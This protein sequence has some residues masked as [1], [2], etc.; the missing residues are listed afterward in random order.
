VK[1]RRKTIVIEEQLDVQ[2]RLAEAKEL[3]AYAVVLES[4]MLACFQYRIMLMAF[5]KVLGV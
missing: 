1:N 2:S 3:F 4:L 5:K